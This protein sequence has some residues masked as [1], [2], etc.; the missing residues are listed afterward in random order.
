MLRPLVCPQASIFLK[1]VSRDWPV[2][3]DNGDLQGRITKSE[4]L[5]LGSHELPKTIYTSSKLSTT[6]WEGMFIIRAQV[7]EN[8]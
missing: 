3:T 5:I 1:I 2:A 8:I 4:I 7:I 6:E